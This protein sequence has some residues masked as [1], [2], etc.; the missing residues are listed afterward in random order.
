MVISGND[1]P[2]SGTIRRAVQSNAARYLTGELRV[3]RSETPKVGSLQKQIEKLDDRLDSHFTGIA[4]EEGI[5][6]LPARAPCAGLNAA[7]TEAKHDV[8]VGK[9]IEGEPCGHLGSASLVLSF[10]IAVTYPK[11]PLS[12]RE[13]V[14]RVRG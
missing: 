1:L 12:L 5:D 10:T 7:F 2:L 9:H 13:R 14:F 4:R 3:L 8:A 11:G 6:D